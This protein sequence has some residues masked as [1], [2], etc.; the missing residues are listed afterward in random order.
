M[1]KL[2]S[3]AK[4]LF[5]SL[6]FVAACSS[7]NKMVKPEKETVAWFES[8]DWLNGLQRTPGCLEKEEFKRQYAA[9]KE[10]WN[11]AFAYLKNTDFVT[12]KPGRYAIDDDNVYAIVSE[13]PLTKDP[14]KPTWEAHQKYY[15]IHFVVSGKEKIGITRLPQ[16]APDIAYDPEKDIEFFN[17]GGEFFEANTKNF[18]IV[19]PLEAHCPGVKP[20]DYDG[21][22]KKVVVKVRADKMK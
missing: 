20:A 4:L 8:K 11:K 19:S 15:D 2:S 10:W 7:S 5:A 16:S 9:H 3:L 22:E 14:T 17:A 21:I 18:F 12:L 6:A 1:P 13:T